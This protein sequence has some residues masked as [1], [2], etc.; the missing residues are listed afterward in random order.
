[1][2]SDKVG[3]FIQPFNY[4]E[5]IGIFVVAAP[6]RALFLVDLHGI[7]L[8]DDGA[9]V[10]ANGLTGNKSLTNL[11]FDSS[12]I[13]SRGWA[14]FSSLLCDTSS[15]NSTYLSNHT[16]VQIGGYGTPLDIVEVLK[17]NEFESQN[18]AAV[19]C[20]ILHSHPDIDVTP[21]FQ[22]NLVCL[23]LLIAR[24]E[25]AKPYW[26]KVNVSTDVF[27]NR[28][29]SAVFKFIRGMP[30]LAGKGFCGQ[31]T[32]DAQLQLKLKSKKRKLDQILDG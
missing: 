7:H 29:L 22:F 6:S 17:W 16:L 30:L 18:N 8:G 12:S 26:R 5:W 14:A 27:E 31:K 25:K 24:L 11:R 19:I 32:K 3:S 13:T 4:S 1:M 15:V 28:Q 2:Q 9:A 23:P 10:L 20:K 21:L